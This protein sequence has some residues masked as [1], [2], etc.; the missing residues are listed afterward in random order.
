MRRAARARFGLATLLLV[1]A[2]SPAVG[3]GSLESLDITGRVIVPG[4]NLQAELVPIRWDPRCIP[5]PFQIDDTRDPIPAPPGSRRLRVKE[6][7]P[8]LEASFETWNEIPTSFVEMNLIGR[9]DASSG[10]TRFDTV[11]EITFR[12]PPQLDLTGLFALTS[13]TTL[14]EDLFLADGTDLDLDGDS[15]VAS[16]ITLCRDI[17]GDG[18]I[19]LPEG[20]YRAGTILDVDIVFNT[21]R[22]TGVRFTV[23]DAKVD[24]DRRSVDLQAVA[25][26][27][28]GH[29]HGLAHSPINQIADDDGTASVMFP[30]LDTGDPASELSQRI[31]AVEDVAAS[32]F[33]YPEGTASSGPAALAL[34]DRA[35]DDVFSILTGEAFHGERQLPLAGGSVFAIDARS[36]EVVSSAVTG[37]VREVILPDGQPRVIPSSSFTLVDSRYELPVPAGTSYRLGIEAPDGLPVSFGEVNETTLVGQVFNLHI[38]P[39]ELYNGG[40][41]GALELRPGQSVP[42]SVRRPGRIVGDFDFVT[43][44][45]TRLGTPG[46]GLEADVREAPPGTFVAVE[47]PPEE[48]EE[49]TRG[50]SFAIPA[51]LF[52]TSPFLASEVVR[53]RR[54]LLT[55]GRVDSFGVARL[56]LKHP[57]LEVKPFLGQQEDAAPLYPSQPV[58]LG[59]SV[60]RELDKAFPKSLFL[61]LEGPEAWSGR[62]SFVGLD[63]ES[64]GRSFVSDDGK[65]FFPLKDEDFVFQLLLTPVP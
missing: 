21:D 30:R 9:T 50:E 44:V 42:V 48:L 6:A 57:L 24:A 43:N 4:G 36:G 31:L 52:R 13:C 1:A 58:Q 33:A 56:S 10:S 54:A 45:V 60:R 17:D 46:P 23:D 62:R 47:I 51:L 41:E 64:S 27:E 40:D 3:G 15:D 11:H 59:K 5:A 34:G 20:E 18:D 53:F 14:I 32:S 26:H 65:R 37:H 63:V 35:F 39:E 29:A 38:F 12:P 8:A 2:A 16:G 22:R 28:L 19:E 25:T 55:T 61:V 7:I 49:A